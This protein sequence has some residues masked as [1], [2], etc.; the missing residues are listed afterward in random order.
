M[1]WAPTGRQVTTLILLI[2]VFVYSHNNQSGVVAPHADSVLGPWGCREGVCPPF[3]LISPPLL[4]PSLAL[5]VKSG[6]AT[7]A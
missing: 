2:L 5:F 3:F 7:S 1:S 4:W 6:G